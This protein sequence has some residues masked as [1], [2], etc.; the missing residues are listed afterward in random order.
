[1]IGTLFSGLT[2]VGS[3]ISS[4]QD[5]DCCARSGAQEF[6]LRSKILEDE[7]DFEVMK[8]FGH[9]RVDHRDCPFYVFVTKPLEEDLLPTVLGWKTCSFYFLGKSPGGPGLCQEEREVMLRILDRLKYHEDEFAG[10]SLVERAGWD[11]ERPVDEWKGVVISNGHV[12]GLYFPEIASQGMN[13]SI[14]EQL[15]QLPFLKYL[16]LKVSDAEDLSILSELTSLVSL[17]LSFSAHTVHLEFLNELRSL[18]HLRQLYLSSLD[19][20]GSYLSVPEFLF[21]FPR[22]ASITFRGFSLIEGKIPDWVLDFDKLTCLRFTRCN[23]R[24]SIPSAI[25]NLWHLTYLNLAKNELEGTIPDSFRQLDNIRKV[26]MTGNNHL[27]A[28][29]GM[30]EWTNYAFFEGQF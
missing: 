22:L 16:N 14:G 20:R 9:I 1:M 30:T 25:G 26:E 12:I 7:E 11:R 6:L 18:E 5:R 19:Y 13:E 3:M 15:R 21:T 23:L 10:P 4:F 17:Y 24:G 29:D 27:R 28:P 2:A 8:V